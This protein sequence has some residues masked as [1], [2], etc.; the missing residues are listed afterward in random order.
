MRIALGNLGRGH[1]AE[2]C[3]AFRELPFCKMFGFGWNS[4]YWLLTVPTAIVGSWFLLRQWPLAY[5]IL[6]LGTIVYFSTTTSLLMAGDG[7]Q[8]YR[9]RLL[10]FFYCLVALGWSARALTRVPPASPPSSSPPPTT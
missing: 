5:A 10:P 7:M 2:F 1:F 9:L 8:R 3:A 6:L 4:L